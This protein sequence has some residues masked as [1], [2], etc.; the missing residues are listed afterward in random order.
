MNPRPQ[1][2]KRSNHPPSPER[3]PI[4]RPRQP[5]ETRLSSTCSRPCETGGVMG[6]MGGG[7]GGGVGGMGGMGRMAATMPVMQGMMMLA[8]MIM[9]FCGDVDSWDQRS[10]MMGMGGMGM[11]GMGGGMGGMGGGMGG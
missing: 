4:P 11:G 8:R 10:L 9:Y 5:N 1:P 6:G 7:M 3:Q 2:A